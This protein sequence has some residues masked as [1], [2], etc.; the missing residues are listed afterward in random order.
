MV[1]ELK[2]GQSASDINFATAPAVPYSET[3]TVG[4]PYVAAEYN[5]NDFPN[6]FKLGDDT[7]VDQYHNAPLKPGTRYAY[8]LRSVSATNVSVSLVR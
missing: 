3:I 5:Y 8:A 2:D 4:M 6:S 7:T 1:A